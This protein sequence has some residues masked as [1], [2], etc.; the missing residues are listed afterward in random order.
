MIESL[1]ASELR[2][3]A[4]AL[5]SGRVC[6]PCSGMALRGLVTG[7]Q[8]ESIAQELNG[9]ADT[10]MTAV[11]VSAALEMLAHAASQNHR[12]EEIVDVVTT[13]PGGGSTR[14]T[15]VVVRD[16]FS[17]A[18]KSVLV[19]GYAVSQ[20]Q[21]VFETLAQ[22]MRE[23]PELTVRLFLDVRRGPGDTSVP[24]AVAAAFAARF[25]AQHWPLDCRL[26][27]VYYDP[28]ALLADRRYPVALHAKCVVVDG[29]EVFVSSANFTPAAQERNIELGLLLKSGGVADR[30]TRFFE[31]LMRQ[32]HLRKL[33]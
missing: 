3:L 9:L 21:Q 24:D 15:G 27:A 16:L 5:D 2:L 18:Q 14:D 8:A 25:R 20:G 17:R 7:E 19:A 1:S 29:G 32:H 4:S 10:G 30:I 13:G 6:L 31:D 11:A 12:I 22:R 23:L 33:L 28:R 26:P